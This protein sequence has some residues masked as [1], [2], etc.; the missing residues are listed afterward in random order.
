MKIQVKAAEQH[1]DI[2]VCLHHCSWI[3]T[4]GQPS[5]ASLYF[6]CWGQSSSGKRT[7]WS[8]CC[9]NPTA[10]RPRCHDNFLQGSRN[11][12]SP[13]S[14]ASAWFIGSRGCS[15]GRFD[16]CLGGYGGIEE[17]DADDFA[18][19]YSTGG[20]VSEKGICTHEKTIFIV[21][22]LPWNDYNKW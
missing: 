13:T 16:N 4:I 10:S 12:C 22:L 1:R 19:P 6:T 18:G 7:H 2:A 5:R 17:S 9:R 15:A 3:I 21:E 20:L 11:L 14:T 8:N